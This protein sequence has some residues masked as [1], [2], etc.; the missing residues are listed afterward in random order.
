LPP[1]VAS[2]LAG[3]ADRLGPFGRQIQ[4]YEELS[5]TNDLATALAARGAREGAVVVAEM[6]RAGRGRLGRTWHSPPGAGL[7]FTIVLRP[8]AHVMPLITIAAGVA[9]AEGVREA[10]GLM[11]LLKWPN[12]VYV[13]GPTTAAGAGRKLAGI[14]AEAGSSTDGSAHVVLGIGI[15][16]REAA[17]PLDVAGRATSLE[18]ELGRTIDRG[19][20]LAG[21]LAAFASRYDDLRRRRGSDVVAAWR[22]SAAP[23]LGRAVEWDERGGVRRGVAQ[24][25]D[26]NGALIVRTSAGAVTLVAGEVRWI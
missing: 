3:A 4:W 18:G 11:T 5:S 14:L 10:T 24:D 22:Q 20:V 16:V 23:L 1:D 17:Y 8:E 25:V 6:Q 15:N 2:A 19:A 26:E 21:C 9:V 12:D 7:Y 13:G